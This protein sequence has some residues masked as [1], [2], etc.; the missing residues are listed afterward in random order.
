MATQE[1]IVKFQ[2]RY[3]VAPLPIVPNFNE[4]RVWRR[5]LYQLELIGQTPTRYQNYGFGNISTRLDPIQAPPACRRFVITG[6]QTGGIPDPGPEHYVAITEVYPQKNLVVAQGP[7]KPSSET[8]THGALYALDVRIRWIMHGHS[9]Q[10]WRHAKTLGI[11][12]T[13]ENVAYGTPEM[14]TETI[15]LYRQENLYRRR[16]YSMGGHEDGIVAFGR[17]AQEAGSVLFDALTRAM[18]LDM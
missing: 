4:L 1:G 13:A 10:I 7:I 2:T 16:I 17:T 14:Q 18:V 8:M 3:T 5:I 12:T 9:P 15:R 6:T 11:P